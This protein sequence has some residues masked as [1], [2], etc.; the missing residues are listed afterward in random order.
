LIVHFVDK[1]Q[2]NLNPLSNQINING[3]GDVRSASEDDGVAV[4]QCNAGDDMADDEDPES[5]RR[6]FNHIIFF[7][8]VMLKC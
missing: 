6:S 7:I 8:L 1:V 3:S 4:G 2:S 5:K